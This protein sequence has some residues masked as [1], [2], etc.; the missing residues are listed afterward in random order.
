MPIEL[1]VTAPP[2]VVIVPPVVLVNA[3]SLVALNTPPPVLTAPPRFIPSG[4]RRLTLPPLVVIDPTPLD[5]NDVP[6]A[7][8]IPPLVV[9]GPATLTVPGVTVWPSGVP[10]VMLNDTA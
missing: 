5:V 7:A 9:I 10:V 6:P 8:K 1:I 3:L 2:S 4:V